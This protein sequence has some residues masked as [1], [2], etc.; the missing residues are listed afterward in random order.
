[1]FDVSLEIYAANPDGSGT[2]PLTSA[3]SPALV[4]QSAT[5]QPIPGPGG[6]EPPPP[7]PGAPAFT[8]AD[9]DG[10]APPFD[11]R[12]DDPQIFP[13]ATDT[14]RDRIDQ[15]CSGRDARFLLLD[16]RVEAFLTTFPAAGYTR[17]TSMTVLP[18]R[19]G[20]RLR[21]TCKGARSCPLR[22]KSI[23][24]RRSKR[25]LSLMRHV[26]GAKLRRGAVVQL[27]VTRRGTIG[28][29]TTWKIRAPKTAT[30]TRACLRPG[31]KKPSRCR[32]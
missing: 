7:P 11:C 15:D 19:K 20:D 23:R 12:D 2:T 21:L 26:R 24:V 10:V 16:R 31:Q 27:R 3:G 17:F 18:V 4:G 9:G 5:W 22:K 1:V 29:V 13:G 28:R 32:S 8:D 30:I 6:G 14:P 25:K